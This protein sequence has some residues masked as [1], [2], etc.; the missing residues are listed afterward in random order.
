MDPQDMDSTKKEP[1]DVIEECSSD[2][3][4]EREDLPL[5]EARDTQQSTFD[6]AWAYSHVLLEKGGLSL[7][8]TVGA[9]MVLMLRI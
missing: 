8:V 1:F 9:I 6:R 7:L 4:S 3:D 5:F 2:C